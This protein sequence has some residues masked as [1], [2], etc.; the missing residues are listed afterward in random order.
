MQLKYRDFKVN[1]LKDG[2]E[3]SK[4]FLSDLA[5]LILKNDSVNEEVSQ[6]NIEVERDR[7][8]SFW[9]F[10]WLCIR[11]GAIKTLL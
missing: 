7:T 2:E 11:E 5:N 6:E 3:G 10:L 8:K 4:S 1:I 9:N